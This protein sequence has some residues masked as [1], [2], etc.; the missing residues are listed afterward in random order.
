MLKS[1]AAALSRLL[2][3]ALTLLVAGCATNSPKL[4]ELIAPLPRQLPPLPQSAE[5]PPRPPACVPD[6]LT[7]AALADER[8]LALLRQ[9]RA[10]SQS[11]SAPIER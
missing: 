3:V 6:C 7:N 11:A 10:P 1:S 9:A 2:C 5:P 4:S 8:S